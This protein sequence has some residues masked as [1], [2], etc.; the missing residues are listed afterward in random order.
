MI[1]SVNLP[2]SEECERAVLGAILLEPE[3]LAM[4]SARL[5]ADD[6]YIGRHR[7]TFAA[8]VSLA[9]AGD[10]IDVRTLQAKL[11]QQGQ[12]D[13]VGGL[14]FLA[15]LDSDLPDISHIASYAAIVK[16]CAVRRQLI[17]HSEQTVR[18]C[19][20]GGVDAQEA[21]ELA[22]N[23]LESLVIDS[24]QR[25]S[26]QPVGAF[27]E[28]IEAE[29]AEGPKCRA[30]RISYGLPTLDAMCAPEPGQL[31]LVGARPGV[32]K[33]SLL[34]QTANQYTIESKQPA[35]IFSLEMT[36]RELAARLI[37]L[38]TG[39]PVQRI[40]SL[41]LRAGELQDVTREG[42]RIKEAGLLIEDS[43]GLP[44]TEIE[45]RAKLEHRR[46]PYGLLLLDY[47]GLIRLP[48]RERPDLE[49]GAITGGLL[50]LAKELRISVLAAA[51][52]NRAASR[53]RRKPILS[54]LRE[55]GSQE[56]DANVVILLHREPLDDNSGLLSE[57]GFVLVAKNRSGRTGEI[58]V[59]F[60]GP[61]MRFQEVD[62]RHQSPAES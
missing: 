55:G 57:N 32:G 17:V 43:P 7:T 2:R 45:A 21:I 42:T 46:R 48:G 58:P 44:M 39:V 49:I 18:E 38:R 5:H 23:R 41:E 19:Q 34:V 12:C 54:D 14:A 4:I 15:G 33:T 25:S 61:R 13:E 26:T 30:P 22:R 31:L 35:L 47:L 51:Q 36:G 20:D 27:I 50:R 28:G 52:L 59:R 1:A 11:E 24:L 16:K 3:S 9:Q 60:D 37:S 6:F 10:P 56:Q 8:M 29:L 62:T 53:E 40:L